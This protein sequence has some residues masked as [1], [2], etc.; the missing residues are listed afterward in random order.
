[1]VL[2]GLE[3]ISSRT[4]FF[5]TLTG[6]LLDTAGLDAGYWYR[7]IRQTVEF[8]QAVRAACEQGY[9]TFIE[10][11]PHPAL[12]AGIED[13]FTDCTDSNAEP[14]V[15]P[16]L[17][18][19]EG[20]IRRFL[21]SAAQAF[22]A[23]VSVDWRAV[24]PGAEFVELP[25]YAFER[26]RFWLSGDG[27][28]LDAAGL[29]LG[30]SEHALLGAV[31]ELPDS[32]GVVLT[33]RLSTASQGWLA[34]HAVDGVVVFPGAG[35][36]ELAIRA[37]DEVGCSVVDELM[38]QSPLMLPASGSVAVQVVV[39]PAEE[40][41]QRSVSVF[42]RE[43]ADSVWIS[44][45]TGQLGSESIE[46]SADLS[47]WPPAGAT[48][49]DV[50][51]GYQ[52]LAARGYEYGSA[53]QGL[54]A[55]WRRGDELFAE[56]TLPEAA[57]GIAGFGVHP[58][59]LD[60]TLHA[61]VMAH[62]GDGVALPFS[63]E[64]VSLHAAGASAV[65]ARIA[66][67][68]PSAVSVE[69]A[70]G[71]G[72]PVL[73]VASMVARP[74]S[75]QQLTAALSGSG[76]DRLFEVVWSP[77]SRASHAETP[78]YEVFEAASGGD[79]VV[80][81]TYERTHT[82]LAAVQSWLIERDSGVLVVATRGAMALPGED[83]TDLAGAAVWGLVRSAQTEHPGRIVLVD[84]DAPLDEPTVTA[85]L[86]VGEP[87]ALVR[88]GT[89]HTARVHASR[90]V[91]GVLVPPGD[92]PWRLGLS[93]AGTFENL[94]LEP[95]PNADATLE[96]G[97]VRVAM[98]AIATNFR[99]V[100]ITLG[101]FTH[102]ALIGGEGAGVVVE[103]GPGV[104]EFAVGDSV[105][106]LFPDGSGTLV[107][108]DVRLLLP[109]PADWSYAEAAAVSVVFTTAWMAFVQLAD[110]KPGQ[111]VLLHAAAGGVGMAAVQL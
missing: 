15:I 69:L 52:R 24:L 26:R 86:A 60:A 9:R 82:A 14:I 5:S 30:P 21:T 38:L 57:G 27:A 84:S 6:G 87:Q 23:G 107:A 94:Q 108:A 80:V 51:D 22:V 10:C 85:V 28:A 50:S 90:A 18:R 40:S 48:A 34:D 102:D 62:P 39:G 17:G 41:G 1:E 111:R 54:T 56:V 43:T 70:D 73:S 72:L 103:V 95:V 106:G 19:E 76:G 63:W 45:A 53:F 58:A 65:R 16:T 98:R 4:A 78:S 104:T 83:V 32:G 12:I 91:D 35:F 67:S 33:G 99:D 13:T 89:V 66:P 97:Q 93:S 64:G 49:V 29:G 100:M 11:S 88:G 37:G 96:P 46:P 59:L 31:V 81:D 79:D 3:P 44:H 8:D 110:A 109:M 25:T 74:V 7:N 92:G 61:A 68:G 55:L 2:S 36:V 47:Q 101:M 105:Y 71:L 77:A 75:Q 20:G 42:S